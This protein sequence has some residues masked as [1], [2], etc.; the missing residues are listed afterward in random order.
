M[1]SQITSIALALAAIVP[2]AFADTL[3][4][5][6]D[7]FFAPG[8]NSNFGASPLINVGGATPYQGLVQFDLSALPA[9]TTAS[10]IARANL[11]L[12]VNKVGSAGAID[13]SVASGPWMES[14]VTGVNPP[15]TGAVVATAVPVTASNEFIVVDATA[16]V[17]SWLNGSPNQ[18]FLITVDAGSP[19]TSVFFDSK[20]SA[21][22]SHPAML[23]VTLVGGGAP[24]PTGPAGPAGATGPAGPQGPTGPAG[25]AGSLTLPYVGA[26]SFT[27]DVFSVRNTKLGAGNAAIIGSGNFFSGSGLGGSGMIGLSSDGMSGGSG[28]V[29]AGGDNLFVSGIIGGIGIV[30][31]G[32]SGANGL[33][34]D[35]GSFTGGSSTNQISGGGNGVTAVGG[36]DQSGIGGAGLSGT[37][38]ASGNL[39]GD[40]VDGLGGQASG[41]GGSGLAGTG[42]S[43]LGGQG[44][45]G[46]YGGLFQGGNSS[47]VA[48]GVGVYAVG[49]VGSNNVRAL[50]G[51]F[52]GNV[53]VNGSLSKNAGS[54]KIDHPLDPA[55]KYLYHSFVESPDMMNIYNGL[56]TLGADGTAWVT[57]PDWF[58]ALNQDFRYQLTSMGAPGPYLY[59]ASEVEGNRFQ[60]AGGAVGARVSWQVTGIRHDAYANAHRIPVEQDKP[61]VEQGLYLTPEL[62][63]QPAEKAI[64]YE[65][66]QT[67]MK[68]ASQRSVP[69]TPSR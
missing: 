11:V 36:G 49:G 60:I 48:P 40:G 51:Y 46:G 55:N 52:A 24:G 43:G 42:V 21:S 10:S 22:T 31:T 68:R 61:A 20:E 65:R 7:A 69:A 13:V 64:G 66:Q 62:F 5:L 3:P 56:I 29:F 26:L 14:T 47:L 39:A 57:M 33:G 25:P 28:G 37:G 2:A 53:H 44:S 12:Y 8:N 19:A 54:F 34:G 50:A 45:N 16:A 6:G 23:D 17:K 30:S 67:A 59:I 63:Q 41:A 15:L 27:G 58:E 35:G 9:G 38:G 4:P 18:G 1:R 32:G